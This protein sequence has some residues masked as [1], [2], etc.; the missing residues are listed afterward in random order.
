MVDRKRIV[1]VV[2]GALFVVLNFVLSGW[3]IGLLALTVVVS[4]GA[5]LVIHRSGGSGD[6]RRGYRLA[7]VGVMTAAL[8]GGIYLAA[9]S[10]GSDVASAITQAAVL[11]AVWLVVAVAFMIGFQRR[12]RV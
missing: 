2:G 5:V 11:T 1:I 3:R 8:F 12:N 7:M 10:S 9:R 4:L 6:P